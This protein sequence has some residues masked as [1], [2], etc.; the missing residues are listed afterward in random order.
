MDKLRMNKNQ[1]SW[2]A[3]ESDSNVMTFETTISDPRWLSAN[4]TGMTEDDAKGKFERDHH[5]QEGSV[6]KR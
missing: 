3:I 6:Q 4:K 5:S 1:M 2:S